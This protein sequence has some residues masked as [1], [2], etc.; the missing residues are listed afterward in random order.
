MRLYQFPSASSKI[1]SARI[2][3]LEHVSQRVPPF[4]P[5]NSASMDKLMKPALSFPYFYVV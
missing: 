4:T 5:K 3:L 1:S 2:S